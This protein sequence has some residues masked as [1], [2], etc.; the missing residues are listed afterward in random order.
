MQLRHRAKQILLMQIELHEL[1]N[2]HVNA[3][4]TEAMYR[5]SLLRLQLFCN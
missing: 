1:A 3:A 2:G 4:I 5:V